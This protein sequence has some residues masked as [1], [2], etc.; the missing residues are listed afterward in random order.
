MRLEKAAKEA[1]D[2]AEANAED[3]LE[4]AEETAED[5]AENALDAAEEAEDEREAAVGVDVEGGD[6]AEAD[7]DEEEDGSAEE[8]EG[9][10]AEDRQAGLESEEN[11]SKETKAEA[12]D[13]ALELSASSDRS[14]KAARNLARNGTNNLD[15]GQEFDLDSSNGLGLVGE[16]ARKRSVDLASV[17]LDALNATV[18][19]R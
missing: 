19:L 9:R 2:E 10:D 15:N 18:Q 3:G 7:G 14:T 16:V 8:F 4:L 11:L 12:G 5:G 6:Q 13:L 1:T 17:A